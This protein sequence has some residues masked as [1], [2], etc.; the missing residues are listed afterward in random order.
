MVGHSRKPT[1]ANDACPE[2]T[3]LLGTPD[4]DS[5]ARPSLDERDAPCIKATTGLE[6]RAALCGACLSALG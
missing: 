1:A 6:V 3:V 2:N 4:G 5:A